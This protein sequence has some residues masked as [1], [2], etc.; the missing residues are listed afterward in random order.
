ML[1]RNRVLAPLDF[2][3]GLL[4]AEQIAALSDAVQPEAVAPAARAQSGTETASEGSGA[5]GGMLEIDIALASEALQAVLTQD[6]YPL[7]K[8]LIQMEDFREAIEENGFGKDIEELSCGCVLTFVSSLL[9]ALLFVEPPPVLLPAHRKHLLSWAMRAKSF[10]VAFMAVFCFAMHALRSNFQS[11][12]LLASNDLEPFEAALTSPEQKMAMSATWRI[13]HWDRWKRDKLT[14]LYKAV[15][16]T[17]HELISEPCCLV[18]WG[19][20]R[21]VFSVKRAWQRLQCTKC[22]LALYCSEQCMQR[23][24]DF[25]HNQV[26][27]QSRCARAR[28]DGAHSWADVMKSQPLHVLETV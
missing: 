9:E 1:A 26:C 7:R 14:D 17:S 24:G 16:D 23:D 25:I 11:I 13:Q 5:S 19:C 21:A 2:L 6:E 27:S 15:F 22:R 8:R 10:E 18:C 12:P 4:P 3:V 28:S 20:E